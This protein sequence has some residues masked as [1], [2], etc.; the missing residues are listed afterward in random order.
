[1]KNIE[2]VKLTE[3]ASKILFI[4]DMLQLGKNERQKH[5]EL[6]DKIVANGIDKVFTVG[7]LS[8]SLF[9]ALPLALRGQHFP[10][11]ATASKMAKEFV[12]NGDVVLVKGSN[13]MEMWRIVR[14]LREM[15]TPKDIQSARTQR[16]GV[17]I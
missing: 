4:G 12:G 2:Y 3:G 13:A 7:G 16:E 1:L 8:Q 6:V 9:E 17:A 5:V 11:A 10:D 14:A 15:S